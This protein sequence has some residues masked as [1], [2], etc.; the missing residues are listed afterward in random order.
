MDAL[1][2]TVTI[3]HI[4]SLKDSAHKVLRGKQGRETLWNSAT[5][6]ETTKL[7]TLLSRNSFESSDFNFDFSTGNYVKYITDLIRGD[8]SVSYNRNKQKQFMLNNIQYFQGGQPNDYRN[9]YFDMPNQK[10]KLSAGVGY[11]NKYT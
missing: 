8:F 6:N 11:D 3:T 2:V 9:N 1:S 7:N 4:T 5:A 10:L